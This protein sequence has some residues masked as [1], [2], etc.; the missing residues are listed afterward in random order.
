MKKQFV[1]YCL[2]LVAGAAICSAQLSS[3]KPVKSA[4]RP[5]T[6]VSL[7]KS[8]TEAF[9]NKQAE[10]FKRY[11]APDFISVDADGIKNADA[12][13]VD[14]GKY[15]VHENSFTD[16][17]VVFLNPEV[18]MITYQGTTKATFAGQDRSGTYNSASVWV[19]RGG[20]WLIVLHTF[21]RVQ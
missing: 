15:D 4:A 11:L 7:E 9:K 6:I 20:K 13:V 10:A 19:K 1:L 16:M 12:E 2:I 21:V 18:A 5:A 14:I 8:I 3:F 17:N